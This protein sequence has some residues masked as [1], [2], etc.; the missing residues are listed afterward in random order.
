MSTDKPRANQSDFVA[1][2]KNSIVATTPEGRLV[3]STLRWL[4]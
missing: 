1:T 2:Q 3:D 4:G